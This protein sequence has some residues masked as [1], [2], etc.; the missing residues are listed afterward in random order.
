VRATYEFIGAQDKPLRSKVVL[1][2]VPGTVSHEEKTQ[3]GQIHYLWTARNVPQIFP[4]SGMPEA[5]TVCQRLLV[6]TAYDWKEVSQ[7]YWKL[8]EP[9]LKS[10]TPEMT[11]KAT[12]LA[13]KGATTE[14]K[15]RA[16]FKFVSQEIRYMGITTEKEAPGYEPH[17]VNITFHNRYGVC[18]DKAALLTS[19][20]RSA[21]FEAFPTLVSAGMKLDREAPSCFFNHAITAVRKPDKTYLLMDSTD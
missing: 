9:H 21:G 16:I 7:W 1:A 6:S 10:A 13:A 20:L 17:D 4:E 15:V 8:C 2:E 12:E 11:A 5:F 14:E 18:R 19:M 3:D